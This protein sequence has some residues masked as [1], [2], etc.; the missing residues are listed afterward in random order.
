[1]TATDVSR[2]DR[3]ETRLGIPRELVR[4]SAL[5]EVCRIARVQEVLGALAQDELV[6]VVVCAFV[7]LDLEDGTMVAVD[8]IS[9]FSSD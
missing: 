6:D 2:D 4:I 7:S 8:F 9:S 5:L 1:M 3:L